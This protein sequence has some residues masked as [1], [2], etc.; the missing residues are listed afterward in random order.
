MIP[1]TPAPE[2]P[3][4]DERV[5][6]PGLDAIAEL[7]SEP[8]AVK[9]PGPKRTPK[10]KRREDLDPKLFPPFWRAATDD[11]LI[12]H[13]RICAYACLYIERVTGAATVDHCVPKSMTWDRVYEWDNYRLACSLMNASPRKTCSLSRARAATPG[14][15]PRGGLVARPSFSR[16]PEENGPRSA[17][18]SLSIKA[19][20][21]PASRRPR[22]PHKAPSA[23]LHR[24]SC[25]TRPGWARAP[26]A[27]RWRRR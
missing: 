9:R 26:A 22:A 27:R 16:N 15:A 13:S 4:F 6:G 12:A 1:L 17:S 25:T 14:E 11:L 23:P 19:P 5:R 10:A 3:T 8:T 21:P 20:A 18:S 7:V 24:R 2:P